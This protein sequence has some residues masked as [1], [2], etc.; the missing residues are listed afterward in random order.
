MA[1]AQS[2]SPPW[3]SVAHE[4]VPW[5]SRHEVGEASRTQLRRHRGPYRAAIPSLIAQLPVSLP[6]GVVRPFLG[7]GK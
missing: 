3:P 1:D 4:E 6:P 2:P 7:G 5:E